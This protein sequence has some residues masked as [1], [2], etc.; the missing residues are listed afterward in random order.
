M[1]IMVGVLGF[2]FMEARSFILG[3][4]RSEKRKLDRPAIDTPSIGLLAIA[5]TRFCRFNSAHLS[6]ILSGCE[7]TA[8]RSILRGD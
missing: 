2:L 3:D 1:V 5:F 8:R 7:T 6:A 4:R